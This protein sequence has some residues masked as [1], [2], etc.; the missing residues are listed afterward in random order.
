[1]KLLNFTTTLAI[2]LF[3]LVIS[4]L[5]SQAQSLSA[6]FYSIGSPTLAEYFVDPAN[7]NDRN[8]GTSRSAPKKTVTSIWSD[9]PENRSLTSGVRIN[10][11]PGTYG[12]NH[13]PN[14]WENRIG[15]ADKPI[16]LSA[17]DGFGT[18][19]FTRDINMAGVSY[20]YLLGISIQNKTSDGYGDAF[21]CERCD[22]ILL[23]GN[24]F[25]GAPS[26][27][28]AGGDVAHET[29]K[30]N[31]SQ[32]IYIE[33]NN[34][35]GADDNGIDWVAVQY[36]HI[37]GNRIHDTDGW[38]MYAKGGSSYVLIEGNIAYN[39]GEGGITAGQGT[40]FEFMT[41]PWARF[42]ANYIKIVNNII[43]DISG[44]A[45]GVN[46]GY[47]ILIAHNTAYKIGTRSH[48]L[49]IV[50]GERSC[51]GDTTQCASLRSAGGWGPVATG[52]S[53]NQPIG[54]QDL[55]VANNI[56]YNPAGTVS[57]SQHFAIYGPRTPSAPGIPSP[58]KT[59][60]KLH[61]S[62]NI[63]WNGTSAMPLGI[64]D[65][66]QG[67]QSGNSTCSESLIRASNTI[68]TSEPDFLSANSEDF[69]PST[70]GR[71]AAIS[72]S[73]IADH[74]SLDSTLNPIS[75][76]ERTNQ[77]VREFS[78]SLIST[79][80]PGAF[81]NANSSIE[82]PAPDSSSTTPDPSNLAPTLKI[83]KA[84]R[85][86][87]GKK[88]LVSITASASDDQ[89]LSSVNASILSGTKV[90]SS[91]ALSLKNGRYNGTK[92]VTNSSKMSVQVTATDDAP[93]ST[94]KIKKLK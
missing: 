80:P 69:R 51:D 78:G 43:H 31:Q 12:S 48:L 58:Q 62:G 20:F 27:R 63:I 60:T 81:V 3:N 59:D 10:L 13:L 6:D 32:Y 75:E 76:G 45:I 68:N 72:S 17:L 91:F 19:N 65:S 92:K 86:I 42:E 88:A 54:N 84:T 85:Q 64:E 89:G 30:F 47:G 55:I 94:S 40:G 93:I 33:N 18:V 29:I 50:Y 36:G 14:Y 26:G 24:S 38:C 66:E 9:L 41:S 34:I 67:C 22:H 57:G 15:T 87:T 11:L 39:C 56:F 25:N 44:A 52:S 8:N 21:H 35:Q 70:G 37:R 53:N 73:A 23:R 5:S 82:I 4:I 2:I 90:L 74:E 79:R 16:I 46:G 77:M 71:I 83:S 28:S 7:G 61:I 1:M 49:E